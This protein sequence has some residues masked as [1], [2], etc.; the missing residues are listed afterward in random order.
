MARAEAIKAG[1]RSFSLLGFS[2]T[3][4]HDAEAV[5]FDLM[6]PTVPGG[7]LLGRRRQARFDETGGAPT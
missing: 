5:V 2:V 3:P 6:Q 7:R 1:V 4:G